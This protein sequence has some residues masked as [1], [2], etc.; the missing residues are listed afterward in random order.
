MATP[1]E[2][3]AAGVRSIS[4]PHCT[5]TA[6]DLGATVLSWRPA[7][8]DEVLFVSRDAA[9]GEGLEI[10]GG[11]PICAPWFGQGR[12]EVEVPAPHGLVRWVPWQLSSQSE[13]EHGTRLVWELEAVDVAHLPGAENYPSDLWFRYEANFGRDLTVRF[14]VGSPT[15]E[16]VL[17]EALHTYFAVPGGGARILGLDGTQMRDHTVSPPVSRSTDGDPE[18][19]A[20]LNAVHRHSGEVALVG[21]DRTIRIRSGKAASIVVWNPGPDVPPAFAADEWDQMVCIEVGN[22]QRDA[23]TVLAGGSHTMVMTISVEARSATA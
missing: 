1:E 9:V 13:D 20:A 8:D 21:P 22:V 19:P 16:F 23:V 17:D 5:A 12:D 10:H 4:N 6:M 14:T 11:I 18:L 7:G 3:A 15:T 2:F